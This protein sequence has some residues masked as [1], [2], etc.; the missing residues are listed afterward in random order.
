LPQKNVTDETVENLDPAMDQRVE[1]ASLDSGDLRVEVIVEPDALSAL[2]PDY[3]RLCAVTENALPFTLFEWHETWCRH[4][5]QR[6]AHI[7]EQFLFFVVRDSRG[8]CVAIFPL[9][10][11]RRRIGPFKSASVDL[12]GADPALTEIRGPLIEPGRETAALR[13]VRRELARLPDWDWDWVQW[14]TTNKALL[15]ALVTQAG[16]RPH[17][18]TP[19]YLIDL[20][21][22]WETFRAGLKRNIRESLRHCYNSLKRAG[23]EFQLKVVCDPADVRPAL[24]RFLALHVMRANMQGTVAHPNRFASEISREFLYEVSEQL[25]RRGVFRLFQLC[26]GR[27]DRISGRRQPLSLLFR[28]R[29]ELGEVRRDDDDRGGG[30]QVC[31]R[32]RPEDRQPLPERGHFQD[33]LGSARRRPLHCLRESRSHV[34]ARCEQDLP[35]RPRDR[36][37]SA[38]DRAQP[39]QGEA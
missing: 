8:I 23:H 6:H 16:V 38:P 21:E 31:D 5:L 14:G 24:D 7:R 30:H 34:L 9:I 15:D 29:S 19:D 26:I 20:P 35:V 3:D 39:H 13:L 1:A 11:S 32:L 33:T 25:A 17:L 36:Q 4:F 37:F 2:K 27:A 18:V 28:L 22:N 10:Y 12:L